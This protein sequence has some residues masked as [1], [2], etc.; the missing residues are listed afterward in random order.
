MSTQGSIS[1]ILE[2]VRAAGRELLSEPEALAVVRSL[3]IAVPVHELVAGAGEAAA[4]DLDRFPSDRLVIKVVAPGI[5]HKSDAGGVVVVSRDRA[6]MVAAI[7]AMAARFAAAG[8]EVAGFSVAEHVE[9]D[10]SFGGELLLGARW[11]DEFGPVVTLGPG[12]I[13]A[14]HLATSLREGVAAA[15]LSPSATPAARLEA[16]L[17]EKAITP[18]IIGGLRGRP[19]RLAM[20]R[21]LELIRSFLAFAARSIPDELA[22]LEINPLALCARGPVALDAFARLGRGVAPAA[23][24]RPL[25]KLRQ[26]L[27]PRS[28]AVVGVSEQ[29]NPGRVILANVLRAGFDRRRIYLVKPGRD[30]LAGCRCVADV[31][32]LPETVDLAVVAIGAAGVPAVV[33]EILAA[34]KAESLILIAGGLGERAGSEGAVARLRAAVEKARAGAGRGPLIHGANCLGVRSRPG[35]YDTLFIPGHKLRF[36]E[37]PRPTPL[38]ILAQSGAFAVA[39]ASQLDELDP[40]YVITVGNQLDLTVGDYLTHLRDDPEIE[41]FACYVEGFRPLDGLRFLEAAAA[42]T[43]AGRPVI[44]YRAG[45]TPEGARATASHTASVAGDYAVTRE[46]ARAAGVV[47]ADD[48]ADFDD[49]VKVFVHLRGLGAGPRLGALSNAGFESV[50]I[51]DHLGRLRL[52][53][54]ADATRRSLSRVFEAARIDAIVEV[55]NPLDVTPILGDEAF[56][57]AARL[58][59]ADDGVDVGVVGC[60][61]LTGAL[62]TLAAGPGHGEDVERPGSVAR[63][64]VELRDEIPKAWVAVVDGGVLYDPMARLLEAHRIPTFR[65][66]DRAL[67]ALGAFCRFHENRK[68][69]VAAPLEPLDRGKV[70]L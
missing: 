46:L 64:L 33:E 28:I 4:V 36:P 70:K 54:L 35:R 61:P 13:Y 42:V 66:A 52:A 39:R 40:R 32:S 55:K 1:T 6:A 2:T 8:V 14:E 23:A 12:G 43:A 9:H 50:A 65:S 63:R 19:P 34:G 20:P 56:A 47:V 3:G 68:Q 18:A 51:A 7:A 11:S 22:E 5:V 27:E 10:G 31:A 53:E 38:A 57:E 58:M 21:L 41:V 62:E 69:G 25:E 30:E 48:L 37:R 44:L 26:L 17:A 24:A 49:L 59:L 15:I 67:R 29:R 60:V 16:I 45:R